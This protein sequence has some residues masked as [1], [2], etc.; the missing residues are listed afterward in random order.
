[1]PVLQNN[2]HSSVAARVDLPAPVA[3]K[4][5]HAVQA[6]DLCEFL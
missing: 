3:G 1:M 4:A 5:M 6:K 2:V